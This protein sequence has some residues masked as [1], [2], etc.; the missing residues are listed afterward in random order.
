MTLGHGKGSEGLTGYEGDNLSTKILGPWG[1]LV[2]GRAGT[3]AQPRGKLKPQDLTRKTSA[4][5]C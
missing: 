1:L 5:T 3:I 2:T 4:E